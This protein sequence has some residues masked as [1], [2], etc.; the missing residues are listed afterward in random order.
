MLSTRLAHFR[1][2]LGIV[3]KVSVSYTWGPSPTSRIS[4][5][6]EFH[7][8]GGGLRSADRG[9]LISGGRESMICRFISKSNSSWEEA[10][11][12]MDNNVD[13]W[14]FSI[15]RAVSRESPI[16]AEQLLGGDCCWWIEY[17]HFPKNNSKKEL[18]HIN[19]SPLYLPSIKTLDLS[20]Q[21][22]N[23]SHTHFK[24]STI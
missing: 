10:L 14:W 8:G 21:I 5:A 15:D 12:S 1:P 16:S 6:S 19:Q 17:F 20:N 11:E 4:Q 7:E 22:R 24:F 2:T 18:H 13:G 3:S 9:K 23:S